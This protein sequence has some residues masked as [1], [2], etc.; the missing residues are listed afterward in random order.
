MEGLPCQ[1]NENF[2]QGKTTIKAIPDQPV[3]KVEQ[4]RGSKITSTEEMYI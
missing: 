3:T 2:E 1:A 4:S